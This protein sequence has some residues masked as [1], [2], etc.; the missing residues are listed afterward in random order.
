[1]DAEV[2]LFSADGRVIE[3][4]GSAPLEA[5]WR[6]IASRPA[7]LMQFD[8]DEG[9][10]TIA[11]PLRNDTTTGAW[12]ALSAR[13]GH[14]MARPARAA[15][16]A[17]APILVAIERLDAMVR[18]QEGAIRSAVLDAL[19]SGDDPEGAL[20]AR[21]AT[22]GIDFATSA[23]VVVASANSP[24]P[25]A[26]GQLAEA[27][28]QVLRRASLPFLAG[29]R[30]GAYVLL[31]QAPHADTRAAVEQALS[32][33]PGAAAGIGRPVSTV[34]AV[35]ASLRDAEIALDRAPADPARWVLAF[36]DLDLATLIATELSSDRLS[37]KADELVGALRCNPGHFDAI[38]AFLAHD[39]DIMRT[40]EALH[41][42]HNSLRYRLGR[43]E[44]ILGRSLKDPATIAS[45]Y[46][47][48]TAH[49][50]TRHSL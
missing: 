42:H 25:E 9:G 37:L 26:T 17:T 19:L 45:L 5:I 46:I 29:V 16:R 28:E 48:L 23:D 6:E 34:A 33:C 10:E 36:E 2:T 21:A 41:L 8:D 31:V 35:P 39:L 1:V 15:A 44:H 30:D 3:R 18:A 12:L 43:V 11:I 24:A 13:C 32:A 20:A 22:L 14:P 7:A 40:A 50:H 27:L 4:T 49:G 47:A 38:V